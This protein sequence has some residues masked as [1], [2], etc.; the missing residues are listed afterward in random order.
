M[1]LFSS[2]QDALE[3]WREMNAGLASRNAMWEYEIP[4]SL[5][6]TFRCEAKTV[7][8]AGEVAYSDGNIP[9]AQAVNEVFKIEKMF[10]ANE[11]GITEPV[12]LATAPLLRGRGL[13]PKSRG[14]AILPGSRVETRLFVI[15]K[16]EPKKRR[17]PNREAATANRSAFYSSMTPPLPSSIALWGPRSPFSR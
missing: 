13:E 7:I 12:R 6:R 14:S 9:I 4:K 10:K 5:R 17:M 3:W 2:F 1:I 11:L 16:Y 8:H 15:D